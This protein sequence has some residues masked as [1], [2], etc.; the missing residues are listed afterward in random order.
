MT[1]IIDI[2]KAIKQ[3]NNRFLKSLPD[4]IIRFIKGYIHQE[5]MN[6]RP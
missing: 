6:D 4:F 3:G 1:R 2:E 5:E